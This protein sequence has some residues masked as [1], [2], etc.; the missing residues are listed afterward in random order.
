MIVAS[1]PTKL[2]KLVPTTSFFKEDVVLCLDFRR[3]KYV[4]PFNASIFV[5]KV[6]LFGLLFILEV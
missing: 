2:T 5:L 3:N 1:T 6:N 4:V